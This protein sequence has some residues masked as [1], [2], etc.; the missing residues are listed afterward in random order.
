MTKKE[1]LELIKDLEDDDSITE[2]ITKSE[3][4][5]EFGGLDIF[6]K[7]IEEDKEF[8]SFID[9]IKDK[10]ASKSLETWKEHN[11]DK[12]IDEK[13]KEIYPEEDPKD[14]ELKRLQ[15]EMENMKREAQRE[16]LMN[17][18]LKMATEKNLPT[19]L[20]SYFVGKDEDTTIENIETFENIYTETLEN[21]VKERI[22]GE[23][24]EPPTGDGEANDD[25]EIL[26]KNADNMTSSEV[27]EIFSKLDEK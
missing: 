21:A 16:K 15:Q 20:V 25:Y 10:H 23:T 11:L 27:A 17:K 1:L 22:K 6:K 7:K 12:L 2:V 5:N 3:L 9:S 4:A 24:Y 18:A 14:L 26:L 19:D 8:K 13:I